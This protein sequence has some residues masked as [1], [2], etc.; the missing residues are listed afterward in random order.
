MQLILEVGA[1]IALRGMNQNFDCLNYDLFDFCLNYDLF[2]F[3][4][5]YDFHHV[6]KSR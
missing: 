3:Y 1:Y 2:D 5:D 4:D 6:K